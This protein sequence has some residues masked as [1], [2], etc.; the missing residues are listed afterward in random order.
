[1]ESMHSKRREALLV[2]TLIVATAVSG[3]GVSPRRLAEKRVE[4]QLPRLIA[5]AKR[6]RVYLLGRHEKMFQGRV[7]AARIVGEGVEIQPGFTLR[8]L[9]VELEEIEFRKDAPLRAKRGTFH[10]SIEDEVLQSYLSSFL[11]PVRSPW[12]LVVSRLDNLRLRS[13]AGEIRLSLDVYTRLGVKL[14][15][16]LSGK[17]RLQ[18]GT[19]IWF[20]DTEMKVVGISVPEKV[21]ELLS[22][23]FLNRPLIDLSGIRA[24]VRIERVA[25]GEG[26]LMFEGTVLVEKLAELTQT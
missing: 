14:S 7:Q 20:E 25:I 11:P 8:E 10:G 26:T 21:R 5:P 16:E 13:R 2:L 19:Q 24:P 17:L 12:N 22:E 15:A 9:V 23:L 3:C 4:A 6:Y 1:M 18:E